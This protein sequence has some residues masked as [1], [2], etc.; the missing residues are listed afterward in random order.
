MFEKMLKAT[1]FILLFSLVV[2]TGFKVIVRLSDVLV[3]PVVVF[4]ICAGIGAFFELVV[5]NMWMNFI[6]DISELRRK[7]KRYRQ[8][9]PSGGNDRSPFIGSMP[10]IGSN[11]PLRRPRRY[12]VQAK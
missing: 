11:L 4:L 5:K 1:M 9:F 8:C 3:E 6:D 12:N 10:G 2:V 7:F